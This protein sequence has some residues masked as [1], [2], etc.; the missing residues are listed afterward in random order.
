VLVPTGGL[1]MSVWMG[2]DQVATAM[3]VC[4]RELVITGVIRVGPAV[5]LEPVELID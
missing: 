2:V 1:V 3:G 4:M 5:M